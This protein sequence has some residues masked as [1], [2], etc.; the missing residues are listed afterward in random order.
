MK[1]KSVL[2]IK[3][4]LLVFSLCISLIPIAAIT[5]IYYYNSRNAI[6]QRIFRDFQAVAESRKLNVRTFL[7]TIKGRTGNFSSDGFIR[8]SLE[9]IT[10]GSDGAG[11]TVHSLNKHLLVNKKPLDR[12]LRAI[13]ITN[14]QGRIV[15]STDEK[16]IG[17]DM[18]D[19]EEFK[20]GIRCGYGMACVSKPYY[21]P[22]LDANCLFVLS[23]VFDISDAKTIGVLVNAY[24]LAC[25][26]EVTASRAG[27]GETGEV[28]LVNKDKLMITGSRFVEHASLKLVVDTKPIRAF[29]EENKEI[30]GIYKDYKDVFVVG[31]SMIIP[32]YDWALIAEVDKSE[33]F[34]PLKTLYIIALIL[35]GASA[36]TVIGVGITFAV[37]ASKPIR[38]LTHAAER[39]ASGDLNHR[40]KVVHK[41]EIGAL[42]TS[43]NVM[44]EKL[45]GKITEH[46][47]LEKT[48]RE[49]K[50]QLQAILD[51]TTSVV[52]LKD[53][54]FRYAFINRQF[55]KIFRLTRDRII[56]RTDYEIFPKEDAD[57]FRSNDRRVLEAK[58]PLEFDEVAPH[59][60]GPHTYISVKFPLFNSGGAVYGICGISTDITERMRMENM[61]WKA[62]QGM[63]SMVQTSPLAIVV[64]DVQGRIKVWNP[65]AERIF[66]WKANEVTGRTMPSAPE[67]SAEEWRAIIE[68]ELGEGTRNALELRRLKKDGSYLDISLWTSWI[69][70]ESGVVT[71]ILCIYADITE[72]KRVEEELKKLSTVIAQS[73]NIVFIAD[74]KG[75]IEYVNPRFEQTTGYT[76]EEAIGQNANIIASGEMTADEYKQ[77]WEIILSGKT[78]RG[79]FKNKRKNG[80]YYWANGL[81]SPICDREGKI[82]NFL[83][84]QEDITEKLEAEERAKHL[85]SFD[86]LTGLLNRTRFI[87]VLNDWIYQAVMHNYIGVFLLI[88]I[89]KF[90]HFNDTYGDMV[91]D[92]LLKRTA[93]MLENLLPGIDTEYY[94]T[95]GKDLEIMESIL[96]RLGA[97]EY[98]VFLAFRN[99]ADGMQTAEEIRKKVETCWFDD[100]QGHL[101]I[102]IGVALY[103]EHGVTIHDLFSKADAAVYRAKELGQNRVHLFQP[104]DRILE[105]MH[106]RIAWKQR[107]VKTIEE[108]RF[109]PWFQPILDLRDNVVHH[110]EALARMCGEGGEINLPS[111]FIDTAETFG[112]IS[113]LDSVIIAKTL[114]YQ[115]KLKKQGKSLSFSI[116]ISGKEVGE[117]S[118]LEF[119]KKKFSE[120]GVNPEQFIIEITE[121]AAVR[122][123]DKAVGFINE[124]R[125]IGCRFAL[126]D[127]GVG[128]TS[129]KYLREM[130]VDYIKIDGSF[131]LNLQDNQHNRLFVKSIADVAKGMGIKTIAEFVENE[132]TVN[133]LRDIGVDYAQGYFIGKPAPNVL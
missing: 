52:Y 19:R 70:D 11:E 9:K 38:D 78:W 112:L 25:L 124:L 28:Y 66:G 8:N 94:K 31:V 95:Q 51:N 79:V 120:T 133:I 108:N 92:N 102:S 7:E 20:H 67:Y 72:R 73:V 23:P 132:Q 47:S 2:S 83:A 3:V 90:R 119:L 125:A 86:V 121:T 10:E 53:T 101:T 122:E 81:I 111:S 41:D 127:F 93:N 49:N 29:L 35:G 129:F 44:A 63:Q 68:N 87:E 33:A 15:S 91:G 89:D 40:V 74:I 59:A 21:S 123:F 46:V 22:H 65:A 114:E 36:V 76:K 56:G 24:D 100:L 60:D 110:Y 105:K 88:D 99:E 57:K 75:N 32:E 104:E 54:S 30:V 69:R 34:A 17:A 80:Q 126:D 82:T 130:Q 106:S 50:E 117:K 107:I 12:F 64:R 131:I 39:I 45:A 37:S 18:S 96:G 16:L 62:N 43:F 97:D 42:A 5:V 103:P 55:E 4:K 77:M 113:A 98:A 109:T 115:S 26:S 14:M 13:F 61:L 27:M 84:I 71:D 128:F 118:L 1:T 85:A 48:L 58:T 116:N 6:M